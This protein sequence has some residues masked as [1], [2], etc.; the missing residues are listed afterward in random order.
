MNTIQREELK[1]L[2]DR[3]SPQN[4]ARILQSQQD[5]QMEPE[6]QADSMKHLSLMVRTVRELRVHLGHQL[7]LKQVQAKKAQAEA[8]VP[9]ANRT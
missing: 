5:L 6:V 3:L 1:K 9:E 4:L 8:K 7:H 2:Q